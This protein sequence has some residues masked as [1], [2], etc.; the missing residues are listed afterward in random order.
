MRNLER[1]V[2]V[3]AHP[4]DFAGEI[5]LALLMRGKFEVHVVNLTHGERGCGEE[6][7]R[8]G[9]TK[10][11]RTREEE[12]VCEAV[13]ATLHWLD[14]VDGEA[15]A[16][17]A[18]CGKFA[19]LLKELRPRAIITHWPMDQHLDHVMA[20]A[21]TMK[22][23]A[24]A[25]IA[26]EI[27]YYEQDRQTRGFLPAFWVDISPVEEEKEQIIGLYE[28]QGGA[29]CIAPNKRLAA[30]FRGRNMHHR[31]AFAEAYATYP[32]TTQGT[33]CIFSE[34]PAP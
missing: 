34:L 10:A 14:E 15:Y 9:W 29:R 3:G 2:F 19:A 20:Y 12:R 4:D 33:R 5:G 31:A 7:F 11:T 8:N 28:C 25:G 32:G 1:V 18:T 21:A 16:S 17:R 13:A 24:I 30:D 22:A 26:P 27:Y 23:V 6:K